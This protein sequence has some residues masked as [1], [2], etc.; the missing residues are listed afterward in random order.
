MFGRNRQERVR[1]SAV[2]ASRL[3]VELARDK[4]FR[5]RLVSAIEH[6]MEA[7]RRA[8]RDF[9]L[10]GIVQRLGSDQALLHEL[11]SARRDLQQARARMEKKRRRHTVRK[12][13]ILGLLALLAGL[14]AL[15]RRVAGALGTATPGGSP[16]TPGESRRQLGEM[17]KEE[18]YAAAQEA[19]IPGRSEMSKEQLVEALRARS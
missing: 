9:G 7:K 15:R 3:A 18:L 8:R 19:D 16:S 2:D 4:T 11:R 17:T 12:I 10:I 5:K 13:L 14:P 1:E 6:G